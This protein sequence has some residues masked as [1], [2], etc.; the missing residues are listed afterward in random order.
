VRKEGR[1]EGSKVSKYDHLVPNYL[2]LTIDN[3]LLILFG[4]I[5][6]LGT[7]S[8]NKLINYPVI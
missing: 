6:A 8:L 2:L 3:H 5:C 1:K 7:A 4:A